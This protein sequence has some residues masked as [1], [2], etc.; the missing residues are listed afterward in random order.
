MDKEKLIGI[1]APTSAGKSFVILLKLLDKLCK[2]KFDIP[3][4]GVIP[5]YLE[6]IVPE[7]ESKE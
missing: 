1:S 5:K 4:L 3:I 7:N 2:E 6:D